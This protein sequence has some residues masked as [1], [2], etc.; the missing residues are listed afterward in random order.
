MIEWYS[1]LNNYKKHTLEFSTTTNRFTT[2]ILDVELQNVS[3]VQDAFRMHVAGANLPVEVLYSGGLDS[4]CVIAALL[5][6]K[7]P[8][9]A[10][11]LRLLLNNAPVNFCDL[12]YSEKFCREH[13]VKHN[14]VDFHIDKFYK[15]GDH[16]PY[17]EPYK[18]CI[19]PPASLLWLIEQCNT[20]PVLGGDYTWPQSH[21]KIY[22]PHRHD[23]NCYDHF[24]QTRGIT[25]IGNMLSH[26]LDCNS[27]FIREHQT[28]NLT[29]VVD[30]NILLNRLGFNL[31]NRHR[32]W[33]WENV[34]EPSRW[35]DW[36]D[37][38]PYLEDTFGPTR[39]VI[40]WSQPFG[41]LI[42]ADAGENDNFGI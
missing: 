5:E 22:S 30:K 21:T 29:D 26:S 18:F 38:V 35:F 42:G 24:M 34:V 41:N 14:I 7:I 39:S 19:I 20:F 17:L 9:V 40:K 28:M 33:G 11:T 36:R 2:E 16:L 32:S 8:V 10:V 15:N 25:G 6:Q 1:G 27:I 12:Y 13:Q 37:Y 23:Y 3:T 4:E 31:E